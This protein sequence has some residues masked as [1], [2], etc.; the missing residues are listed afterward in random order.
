MSE[1][2]PPPLPPNTQLLGG[3][4]DLKEFM[5]WADDEPEGFHN[6]EILAAR[7]AAG[8]EQKMAAPLRPRGQI[9]HCALGNPAGRL[10][11]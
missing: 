1:P 2:V 9:G 4:P 11:A 8:L 6:W 5:A 3:W 10:S 7:L